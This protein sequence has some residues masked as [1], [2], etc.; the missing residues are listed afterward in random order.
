MKKTFNLFLICGVLLFFISGCSDH[1]TNKN[2]LIVGM[3]ADYP[4]FEFKEGEH[5]QGLDVD[6]AKLIGKQLNKEIEFKDL[7]F[8]SLF[9]A[10]NSGQIDLAISTI[11]ATKERSKIFD[12]SEPYYFA[13][14]ALI[15]RKDQPVQSVSELRTQKIGAQLGS[16]MEAWVKDFFRDANF[17]D[18]KLI[19]MDLNPQLIE[20]LKSKQIDIVVVEYV[21]AKEFCKRNL[22]L[23]YLVAAKSGYGYAVAMKKN[24]ALLKSV[25]V[26]LE[27]IKQQGDFTELE[28]KW[29][30][31]AV[32][33]DV[34]D[35]S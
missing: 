10:L 26:A 20:A 28:N 21:Q 7:S 30:E 1:K 3:S 25:D 18:L 29:L 12:L 6:L 15:F 34:H 13:D 4:P 31:I 22:D 2:K 5:F 32:E 16:T 27:H 17:K 19:T 33:M 23:G 9:A 14:L 24:S 8:S 35:A 11:T